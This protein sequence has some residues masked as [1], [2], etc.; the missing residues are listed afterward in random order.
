MERSKQVL[1]VGTSSAENGDV[2]TELRG[3]AAGI[4]KSN[5]HNLANT[6][7]FYTNPG[8]LESFSSDLSI[9]TSSTEN[10]GIS[11]DLSVA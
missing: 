3:R 6:R 2:R 11:N 9:A 1:S 10:E 5:P 8:A 4:G 7:P